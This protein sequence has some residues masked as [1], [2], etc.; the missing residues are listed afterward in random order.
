MGLTVRLL[1]IVFQHR[2]S[3]PWRQSSDIIQ[4]TLW[5]G[6]TDGGCGG[7]RRRC[8]RRERCVVKVTRHVRDRRSSIQRTVVV[9]LDAESGVRLQ[10][11]DNDRCA[12][13]EDRY[14]GDDLKW[15]WKMVSPQ[16]IDWLGNSP[17]TARQRKTNLGS[18]RTGG[19]IEGSPNFRFQL[20]PATQLAAR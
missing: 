4:A 8:S 12:N 7:R 17:I 10:A 18:Q 14:R 19:L 1:P 9:A 15:N 3:L 13:K 11:E 6:R 20:L 16:G 5:Q 2:R